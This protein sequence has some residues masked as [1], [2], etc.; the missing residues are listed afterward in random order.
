MSIGTFL[1]VNEY[2][3]D[4][5]F[6]SVNHEREV[7]EAVRAWL[8]EQRDSILYLTTVGGLLYRMKASD[9]RSWLISAPQERRASAEW[10]VEIT[11]E[12]RRVRKDVGLPVESDG[13][14]WRRG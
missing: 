9:V 1:Q 13:E 12:R 5:V 10:E 7:D 14:E 4:C 6:V 8:S 11:A 2:D 3:D